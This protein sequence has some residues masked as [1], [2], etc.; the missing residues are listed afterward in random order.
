MPSNAASRFEVRVRHGRST[1]EL[2]PSQNRP[3]DVIAVIEELGY[4][5]TP[6]P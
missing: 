6:L 4:R 2:D 3:Q 5:G 1:V